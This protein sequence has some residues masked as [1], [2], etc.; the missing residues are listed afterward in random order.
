MS[1]PTARPWRAPARRRT[2][3]APRRAPGGRTPGLR[4]RRRAGA[5]SE[6]PRRG[7]PPTSRS[8]RATL[9]PRRHRAPRPEARAPPTRPGRRARAC[10]AISSPR[11]LPPSVHPA[12][13]DQLVGKALL[14]GDATVAAPDTPEHFLSRL[15]DQPAG[16][17]AH[18]GRA[19]LAEPELA[20]DHSP[21][22]RSA[23]CG[24][25]FT[26]CSG[27][28]IWDECAICYETCQRSRGRRGDD[29][30]LSGRAGRRAATRAPAVRSVGRDDR[31]DAGGPTRADVQPVGGTEVLRS[32]V[33]R[34]PERIVGDREQWRED[35]VGPLGE[36]LER[37]R[38]AR[39]LEVPDLLED[40]GRGSPIRQRRGRPP[41]GSAG[42]RP[43]SAPR[44]LRR[45]GRWRRRRR[46]RGH[47]PSP[48]L[49]DDPIHLVNGEET[50]VHRSDRLDGLHTI[51][52]SSEP[53]FWS[54][55]SRIRPAT[56]VPRR[57]ASLSQRARCS[58]VVR[59]WSRSL[60]MCIS[61]TSRDP[62][63]ALDF[64]P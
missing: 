1:A 48:F 13:A 6:G 39:T 55:A 30:S 58:G 9:P 4:C 23:P 52:R 18:R 10:H 7:S 63:P 51:P 19:A 56:D 15:Q 59:T 11:G 29:R 54:T 24:P 62:T 36:A 40:G 28:A 25:T 45:R 12:L 46:S 21:G 17:R 38:P 22:S 14:P 43:G 26:T 33:Q 16:L 2:G 34:Q 50:S 8:H 35:G 32:N 42:T 47:G 27:D 53:T 44:W 5:T 64:V 61:Y 41:P 37:T 57:F 31:P 49:L 60:N 20:P 3:T